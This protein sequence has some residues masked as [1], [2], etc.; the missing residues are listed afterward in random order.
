M[1]DHSTGQ[2]TPPSSFRLNLR[3]A[4]PPPTAPFSPLLRFSPI[5]LD[6]Y[7]SELYRI[8]RL[9]PVIVFVFLFSARCYH[10]PIC[11]YRRLCQHP[12]TF[13]PFSSEIAHLLVEEPGPP[14]VVLAAH[15]PS[16]LRFADFAFFT[17]LANCP[18]PG[19]SFCHNRGQRGCP[20]IFLF[21]PLVPMLLLLPSFRT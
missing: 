4:P 21:S 10:L 12:L 9:L 16:S 3:L 1:I 20:S 15:T 14:P 18:E 7:A 8:P 13:G 17:A 19:S 2:P 6:A 5:P 11:G